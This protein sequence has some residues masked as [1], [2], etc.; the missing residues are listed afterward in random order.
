MTDQ[1]PPW[2]FA[3][4]EVAWARWAQ[5]HITR[6][7]AT[8]QRLEQSATMTSKG[9]SGTITTLSRNIVALEGVVNRLISP[10][11][12][13]ASDSGFA[14]TS[15]IADY[16]I[17]SL[18][19]PEGYSQAV[20]FASGLAALKNAASGSG[21]SMLR[22]QLKVGAQVAGPLNLSIDNERYDGGSLS[23][24]ALLTGL[25]TGDTIDVSTQMSFVGTSSNTFAKTS[26]VALFMV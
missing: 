2:K 13:E 25:S 7:E 15:A 17:A 18:I 26:A 6:L 23:H 11:T 22:I 3:P 12:A 5:E 24:T 19:V 8:V 9:Q 1:I 4:E 10:A 16:A 21:F 14:V 20:V